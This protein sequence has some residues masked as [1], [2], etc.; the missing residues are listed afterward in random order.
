[1]WYS[2]RA[3]KRP[4]EV[5]FKNQIKDAAVW[6]VFLSIPIAVY[7]SCETQK[8]EVEHKAKLA[9]IR[10]LDRACEQEVI[11]KQKALKLEFVTASGIHKVVCD[12][13]GDSNSCKLESKPFIKKSQF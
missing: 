8:I 2:S 10:A 5:S 9:E 12:D 13:S 6:G 1:M 7:S 4:S 3:M 11:E